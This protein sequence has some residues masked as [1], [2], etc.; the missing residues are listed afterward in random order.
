MAA[1]DKARETPE[2]EN[3]PPKSL[4][5]KLLST[6][7][8]IWGTVVF[9]LVFMVITIVQSCQPRTGGLLYNMCYSFLE[10]Q[11]PFPETISP[12]EIELYQK[13][14]RIY[15]THTD[16]FGEYRLEMIEC[17][18][19]QDPELGVQLEDVFF[20]YVKRV[21]EKERMSG[22]GRLYRVQQSY[23]DLFNRSRSPAAM[24]AVETDHEIPEDTMMRAF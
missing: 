17:A 21:T 12:S 6:K 11:V 23:I 16:G 14:V 8:L 19:E 18:F 15:Y 5:D 1:N 10:M 22:K 4:K 20:N 13:G 2:K 3:E 7:T 24:T 9:I